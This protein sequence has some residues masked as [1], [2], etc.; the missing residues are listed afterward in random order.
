M[1]FSKTT[2]FKNNSHVGFYREFVLGISK[3]LR[4]EKKNENRIR[5]SFESNES[6]ASK[7]IIMGD[8]CTI[9]KLTTLNRVVINYNSLSLFH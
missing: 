1:K 5:F 8:S 3:M 7:K 6:R 2:P 4:F 9:I